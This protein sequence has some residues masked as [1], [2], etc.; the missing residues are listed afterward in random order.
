MVL[1][2]VTTDYLNFINLVDKSHTEN[3]YI[4]SALDLINQYESKIN[5]LADVFLKSQKSNS[6]QSRVIN[7]L[8]A[9]ENAFSNQIAN[10]NTST[11]NTTRLITEIE[12]T[13]F[14]S[15][16]VKKLR[17]YFAVY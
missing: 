17:N 3:S 6:D 5:S 14:V 12:H 16:S 10:M 15:P 1:N 11:R 7:S 2:D 9:L 13:N 8:D 4:N